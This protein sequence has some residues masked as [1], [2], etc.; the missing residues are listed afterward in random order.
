MKSRPGVFVASLAYLLLIAAAAAQ[1]ADWTYYG[2]DQGGTRY[3]PLDQINRENV[4][5]LELAWTHR[6]GDLDKYPDYSG[7]AGYH[8]TPIL[9]PKAAGRSLVFCTP[10]NRIIAVDP[11]TGEERWSHAPDLALPDIPSRL[12]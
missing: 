8:T 3:S 7:F 12:K 9:L 5:Q 2:F 4:T 6:Y 1:N 10:F 11:T